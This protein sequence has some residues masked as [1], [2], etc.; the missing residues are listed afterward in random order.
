[1]KRFIIT[2]VGALLFILNWMAGYYTGKKYADLEVYEM[3]YNVGFQ[4]AIMPNAVVITDDG[5]KYKITEIKD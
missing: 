2:C 1:M 4:S 3:G 5:K